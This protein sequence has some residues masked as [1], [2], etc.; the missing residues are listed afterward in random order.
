M[1]NLNAFE[2]SSDDAIAVDAEVL[3]VGDG[4]HIYRI[5]QKT[6]DETKK[7]VVAQAGVANRWIVAE[8]GISKIFGAEK[9]EEGTPINKDC[10]TS[11]TPAYK[12][13]TEFLKKLH[14]LYAKWEGQVMAFKSAKAGGQEPVVIAELEERRNLTANKIK[15][16]TQNGMRALQDAFIRH[17][18]GEREAAS[19]KS[20]RDV[21]TECSLRMGKFAD[22]KN[23][24]EAD[25]AM[26]AKFK[27]VLDGMLSGGLDAIWNAVPLAPV[28]GKITKDYT[29]PSAVKV[30]T[31]DDLAEA[32]ANQF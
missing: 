12:A 3:T 25:K 8:P 28:A 14:P 18:Q 4:E 10:Y 17:K 9:D 24:T 20:P 7:A 31:A 19:A 13:L 1:E 30:M 11:G 2:V 29:Q 23:V 21:L 22:R 15:A 26:A 16:D 32:L 6:Y 5:D 27:Q